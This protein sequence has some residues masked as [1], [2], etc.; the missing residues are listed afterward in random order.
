MDFLEN[1]L[2]D[3][4]DYKS[5]DTNELKQKFLEVSSYYNEDLK[6]LSEAQL[7][8]NFLQPIFRSL[9]HIYEVQ[10]S[11]KSEDIDEGTKR[12]DYAF[13]YS[14]EDKESFHA[15]SSER[16]AIKYG[17]CSTICEAK[18]WSLLD[19]HNKV[20]KNDNTDPIWQIKK[21]YLD[22]INPKEQKAKVPFGILTDGK[23]W[24]I[25]SYR[26]E[27]DKFFELNL[28]EII[29][30]K[31]FDRFKIF[32]FFFSKEAFR[33]KSYLT[34]VEVGSKK[35][36]SQVSEDLRK[37]VYLSL[38]LIATGLFRAYNSGKRDWDEFK[39]Y[40]EMRT[41]LD[42]NSIHE[43]DINHADTEKVIL[44]IIYT[45]SL[46]YLFRVLF[47]LYADHRNLFKHRKVETV[48][49]QLL[50]K[51]D[52][53]NQIGN[54][55]EGA[56][57]I[58]DKNDDYDINGVFEEIDREFNGGLFSIKLHT[59]LN[60]FD[61]DNILYANA[62]DNLTR[63]L[64]KKTERPQRVDFS[65]LEVRHLGTIYEGLLEY[66]LKKT[67]EEITIPLLSDK[68]KTRKLLK[69]DL[70][71]VNDKGERKATGSYYTPDYIVECIVKN[72]VGPLIDAIEKE[73]ISIQEK[74]L[75]ILALRILD[76]AMGSGHFL[77]EVISYINDRIE[78]LIQ[79]ELE[80]YAN[81]P[82]RK[83]KAQT[84][85]ENLLKD[86]E[87]GF[88]KRIIAKKCIYGVDKNP[89]A[90]ELAK[91]SIW[92]YTLQRNKKLEF[93][94]YN[95]RCGD[96]L[97]GSQEKTFSS[98]LDSQSKERMLFANN[99]E[100]YK[101]VVED[102][103]EEFK[104]YFELENVDD[105]MKYYEST[106]KPNQQK[107]K[108]L[109][110]IELAIAFANKNDEIHS[111]Y[112][113]H[114][115]KL[116]GI[117]RLDKTNE[118]LKKLIQGK[119]LEDWELKLFQAAKKI[120]KDYNPIHWE[121]DFPNVFIDRGGFDGIVGNPPYV[122][123][124]SFSSIEKEYLKNRY[125][126]AE[127]QFDLFHLFI[128][129]AVIVGKNSCLVSYIVPNTFLGNENSKILR[130]FLLNNINI[131]KIIDCGNK[132]F[133]EANVETLIF[134]IEKGS[135]LDS[136]EY[137]V[138][139]NKK[140][141]Y[142][143]EFNAANFNKNVNFNFSVTLP[144]LDEHISAKIKNLSNTL[145]TYFDISTGIK[146][147]Q[148]G[149]GNPPQT[150]EDKELARFNSKKI[151]NE[152]FKPELRGK[153]INRY[154][155]NWDNDY[156]SYGSWIAEPRDPKFFDGKK[157]LI[158]QIPGKENL[159]VSFTKEYFIIDQTVFIAKRKALSLLDE[160]YV[161][162]LLNSRLIFWFFRNEFNEFDIL[163]PK[164]K[165]NEFKSLP[166][167][168]LPISAQ[169]PFIQLADTMLDKN[170]ELH[171]VQKKFNKL[172]QSDLKIEKLTERLIAW[173]KLSWEDFL[174]ELKKKK[175]EL[176]L[177]QKAEWMD[178]FEKE[179]AKANAIEEVIT[180]TDS[181]IDLMVYKLYGLT[182]EEIAIV[183]GGV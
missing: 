183:E 142:K 103:K 171:E 75:K 45:E 137:Y 141:D 150:I 30:N 58:S 24:R 69:G 93:F 27:I 81:K 87:F 169:K 126:V 116:L 76:P 61:I 32:W 38:E 98:Q 9:G 23:S 119:N 123:G 112:N 25:Y 19:N 82:G 8:S 17:S 109:A 153:N 67:T 177:N 164:I 28:E 158:R 167:I 160:L 44:D 122:R 100:L 86:A 26:A 53:Y 21:S 110:N 179:K 136:G 121:L 180:K 4:E 16:N 106:I 129:K 102:F 127:N 63:T 68:N 74:I 144:I 42:E 91:L 6:K 107:L 146:E 120:R 139:E 108:Y 35:L 161:L 163:F 147:Y 34:A 154:G 56:E 54:I 2:E 18:S 134:L 55:P 92:I 176:K 41:F 71:L 166:I 125:L 29:K 84:E 155:I 131:L 114:K 50:D 148:V 105:R 33:G 157:I 138:L 59:I 7:E 170:K 5:L 60:R 83:S 64:D 162:C 130:K 22:N 99:E 66:K 46:V 104:K 149:K 96:S 77:V 113:A 65:V 143:H 36:Q 95:L 133:D 178:F 62:I 182:E 88:Y 128:E 85:L 72:T 152:T 181:E 11:K 15:N 111:I 12:I 165:A 1:H 49:Y 79:T 13:F 172:L 20:L 89:M 115:N 39:K 80:E 159:I 101:N 124:R 43:I 10:T 57:N 90:V 132:V 40:S 156:I 52:S 3:L 78:E 140:F 73:S 31:D 97:I 145:S 48:F 151:I 174:A 117:I 70:F 118:Y 173:N 51:I 168:D 37:Q 14:E 47:L 175:I 135:K 94:D